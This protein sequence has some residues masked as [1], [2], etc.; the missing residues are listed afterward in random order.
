MVTKKGSDDGQAHVHE[1]R[2]AAHAV[3]DVEETLFHGL[4]VIGV[5]STVVG[6]NFAGTE[7][8]ATMVTTEDGMMHMTYRDHVD[9]FECQPGTFRWSEKALAFKRSIGGEQDNGDDEL[10]H[11]MAT[12]FMNNMEFGH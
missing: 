8:I 5:F 2:N 3:K 11:G 4:R 1:A 10:D 12:A 9:G 7:V 6:D